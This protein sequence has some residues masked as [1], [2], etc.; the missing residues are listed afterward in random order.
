MLTKCMWCD[1]GICREPDL[2]F[3]VTYVL[4]LILHNIWIHPITEAK[5]TFALVHTLYASLTTC[6]I[7][8]IPLLYI[9]YN[10]C[11]H[12]STEFHMI[13]FA[14]LPKMLWG[15]LPLCNSPLLIRHPDDWEMLVRERCPQWTWGG[16]ARIMRMFQQG[17]DIYD[18][19][20]CKEITWQDEKFCQNRIRGS[21]Y[22]ST[23][24][25]SIAKVKHFTIEELVT[26]VGRMQSIFST[27]QLANIPIFS[28][29]HTPEVVPSTPKMQ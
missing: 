20:G 19:F 2:S 5:S 10:F 4:V 13:Y 25:L 9:P 11:F 23:R 21:D 22:R 6:T 24:S 1:Y 3:M 18:L 15:W 26:L 16:W 7:Y 27:L 28:S 12:E 8:Y 17:V 14:L 29:F